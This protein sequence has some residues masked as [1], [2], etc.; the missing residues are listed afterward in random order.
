MQ[1]HRPATAIASGGVRRTRLAQLLSLAL[2]LVAAVPGPST[3]GRVGTGRD[4]AD[5]STLLGGAAV[6]G[7]RAAARVADVA[8]NDLTRAGQL[9]G[10]TVQSEASLASYGRNVY[11]GYNDG[12]NCLDAVRG[13]PGVSYI[14]FAR[15]TD[16]GR[17]FQDIG[18]LKPNG[19]VTGLYGDPVV[20]VDT[21]GHDAGTV[22]IASLATEGD[23]RSMILAVGRSTDQGRTF[24][25]TPV[26]A[27]AA[28]DKEWLTVDNSGGPH[29]GSLYLT[30][31]DIGAYGGIMTNFSRDGGR[32]WPGFRRIGGDSVHGPRVA[33]G[34]RSELHVVWERTG[35]EPVAIEWT[36]SL[37]GGRSFARPVTVATMDF[38]GDDC[39]QPQG[40]RVSEFPSIAVDT[41]G[42]SVRSS[43]SFNP[44][45]GSVYVV[46]AGRGRGDDH[47]DIFL[48][49]L[50][51]G[52]TR[53]QP[54]VRV[55]DDRTPNGQ[56][57]PEIVSTGPGSITITWT[58][59]R[60][61]VAITPGGTTG[62]KLM[63]QWLATSVDAGK[64]ISRN[65]PFSDALFPPPF[66]NPNLNVGLVECYAGDY[67]GLYSD[68]PGHVIAAWGDNRDSMRVQGL[69]TMAIPDPNVFFRG[70]NVPTN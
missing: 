55:N 15:S 32:T 59:R 20:A 29:D 68:R 43:P 2:L 35:T 10:C 14:G 45:R 25:W 41:H 6:T 40:M 65:V 38:T 22:Y 62:N 58:D 66:S 28:P 1:R 27:G 56:Y 47:S 53:W 33:V 50:P 64:T 57:W 16:S 60:E 52:A 26:H 18:P 11:V 13:G 8:V 54:K 34:P 4:F 7:T 3:A 69:G 36:R 46:F 48:A 49:R 31:L 12:S 39:D 17:T 44:A 9:V 63:R 42:S 19:G 67:N 37:D 24:R 30:W 23:S 61:D 70:A 5:P 21:R 51:P